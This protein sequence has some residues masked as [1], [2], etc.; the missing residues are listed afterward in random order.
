MMQKKWDIAPQAPASWLDGCRDLHPVLAQILFNRGFKDVEE[1]RRFLY[2]KDLTEDPYDMKD[3]AKAVERISRAIAAHEPI[4]VYGDFDADGVTA[5]TLM[6]QVLTALGGQ[7][8]VYFPD[9]EKDG[10]GLHT[11]K[12]EHLAKQGAKVVITVDCGIRSVDEVDAARQG[13]IDMIITDHHSVG[14]EIPP[15]LAV[16]NPKQEGCQGNE[17]LAGVGVAFM[18][19]TAL[20]LHRW[21]TDRASYPEGLRQSDLLDLVAIGTVADVMALNVSLNRRLVWHGLNTINEMRRPGIKALAAVAGL[22]PGQIKTSDI[23]FRL[24]PR[25]NAAG[26]L[27]DARIAYNLLAAA[28]IDEAMAYAQKLDDAQKLHR[29]NRERQEL[30]RQAEIAIREQIE[31]AENLSLIFEGDEDFHPGI[32]GLVAGQLVEEYYRPAVVFQRGDE[33]SRASC[34]SIPEFHITHALDQCADLLVRHGGHA[35]AAGFTVDNRNLDALREKLQQMAAEAFDGQNLRPTLHLDMELELDDLSADLTAVLDALEP[36]GHQHPPAAFLTRGLK[37]LDCRTVGKDGKHL[38]LK[39]GRHGQAPIDAIGFRMGDWAAQMPSSI[40]VA[41][42]LEINEWNGHRRLQMRLL[43]IR[44]AGA[45]QLDR[46]QQDAYIVQAAE[47]RG[48]PWNQNQNEP[49]AN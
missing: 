3:M 17:D 32:V 4:V 11:S 29:I 26:R 31:D 28:S 1:A 40:D 7:A 16:I 49:R 45:F 37:A 13:G 21:R 22:K 34:R 15:A 18:L 14:A 5:A 33:Q 19:A 38:K 27:G 35:M 6:M 9:R 24:G 44:P 43:D 20:L 39:F 8:D 47:N 23:G 2:E 25:I 41:Y 30:T 48:K 46:H 12:L 36:T 10:Y 42:H